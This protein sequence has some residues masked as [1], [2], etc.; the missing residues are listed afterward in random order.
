[1]ENHIC[2]TSIWSNHSATSKPKIS[3][4]GF[5]Y[6]L[7]IKCTVQSLHTKLQLK[8]YIF[9]TE[10]LFWIYQYNFSILPS[11]VNM[12]PFHVCQFSLEAPLTP[13]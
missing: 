5:I 10:K 6:E 7:V 3:D 2:T 9:L 4:M 8:C 1:M 11:H 13:T 12:H